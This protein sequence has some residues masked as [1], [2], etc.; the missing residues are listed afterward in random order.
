MNF[1]QFCHPMTE[2]PLFAIEMLLKFRH[3]DNYPKTFEFPLNDF[4]CIQ[5]NIQ[6]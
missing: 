1:N 4:D 3:L 6:K 2:T 5:D